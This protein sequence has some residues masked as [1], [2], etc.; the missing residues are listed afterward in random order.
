MSTT[1]TGDVLPE[2]QFAFADDATGGAA[3]EAGQIKLDLRELV[4]AVLFPDVVEEIDVG[5]LA[6]W[7]VSPG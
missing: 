7:T 2:P 1:R 3:R 4:T 5:C 6:N